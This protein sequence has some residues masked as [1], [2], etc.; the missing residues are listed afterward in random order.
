[1][2]WPYD[3]P[4]MGHPAEHRDGI[5]VR[6]TDD[7]TKVQIL[8][9]PS[10]QTTATRVTQTLPATS[11]TLMNSASGGTLADDV[12]MN[13]GTDSDT[14]LQFDST[15]IVT[16]VTSTGVPF[17]IE[18]FQMAKDRIYL[19]EHFYQAPQLSAVTQAPAGDTYN[20]A[21][22]L[23]NLNANR[24]FEVLGTNA[25]SADVT[26]YVEGGIAVATHG[27]TND[28]TIILPHLT[29]TQSPW[30]KVTWGTDQQTAWGISFQTPAAVTNLVIWAGLKLTNTPTVA[31]DAKQAFFIFDTAASSD[32]TKFHTV[33]SINGTDTEAAVGSAVTAA[34]NYHLVIKIDSSRIARFY[35]NGTLVT[36][37]TALDNTTDFIP[38]FGVKDLSAGSARTA[39]LFHETISRKSG[40]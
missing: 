6:N 21:T 16:K 34:T 23:A 28:S 27:A 26:Q 7:A 32:A 13:I 10:G 36:T 14:S 3:W 39:Y 25:V 8:S 24:Y 17:E 1:M 31:T 12:A 9:V 22:F 35:L 29:A 30:T 38:Y 15:R 18:Q 5:A 20:T 19:L 2:G 37:S 4:G 40:A 11:G 33:Y